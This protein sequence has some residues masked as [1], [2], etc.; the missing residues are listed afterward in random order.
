M[1]ITMVM[2]LYKQKPEE[3][4]TYRTLKQ[5]L[6]SQIQFPEGKIELILYDNS[7]EKQGFTPPVIEGLHISYIHD[8]RNLGIATA[9]NYAYSIAK[10]NGSEWLLLLD[11][12]TEL[13]A[14]YIN[15]VLH[16]A[17][18]P[19]EA[20]AV[21]PKINSDHAM[22]SPVYSDTLRP[23]IGEKPQ[24][25]IQEKPV[26]AIN[27]GSLIKVSFLTELNGF[28]QEFA[29]D[30]LDHW[31]FF[32]IY[33]K[34]YKVLLLDTELEHELSVMDYDRV[35]L[36][37]YKSILDSETNFYRN[38]KKDL[39]SS[40]R[41]QLVKRFLKQILLVKNKKIATYTLKKIFSL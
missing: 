1:N 20:A 21:V 35:S 25:G 22:I 11:H 41:T 13:T 28:N 14:D 19:E 15:R 40:Y 8:E 16:L 5:H 4:K 30:Y 10:S 36:N 3:S 32:E 23:L 27:S 38:Y 17:E 33:H 39:F 9:Y 24:T 18:V 37:R 6:F 34:G 7:P 26:M 29:L 2:V 12:D 31:L